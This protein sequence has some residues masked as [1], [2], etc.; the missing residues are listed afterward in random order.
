MRVSVNTI[1]VQ[2]KAIEYYISDSA[3]Y[4]KM[5]FF[6]NTSMVSKDSY[7]QITSPTCIKFE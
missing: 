4:I 5:D 6:Y 7:H 3:I 2:G 1:K